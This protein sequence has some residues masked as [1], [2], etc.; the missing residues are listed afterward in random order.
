MEKGDKKDIRALFSF[1]PT[2]KMDRV[3]FLFQL[4]GA[5]FFPQYFKVEDADFHK[6]IDENNYGLYVGK[7]K[8]FLLIGFRGCSKTTREKLWRAFVI[9]ND[10]S[11]SKKY[12]KILTKDIGNAK[13]VVTDIYN[14]LMSNKVLYYYPEIF[15]KTKE[16]REE[17][18]ESFTTTTGIKMRAGTV[19]MDQRGQIQED[20]RPDDIWF[21]DFETRKVLRSA[22][23]IKS[24]SDNMEEA[25]TGLALNG[26]ATYTCNFLSERGNVYYLIEKSLNNSDW[27]VMN[28]PIIKDDKPTW[29]SAYTVE[30]I[31]N[32]KNNAEDFNGEYL[33]D[34]SSGVDVYFDRECLKKQEVV[35]PIKTVAGFKIFYD[36]NPSHKYACGADVG[37]GVGLDHSTSVFIDFTTIP[38]RV[39]ATYKNNTIKPDVFGSELINQGNL[40]GR[41]LI[42]PE[43]NK[44]DMAI[45]VLKMTGYEKIYFTEDKQFKVRDSKPKTY[46]WNTNSMTKNKM[47]SELKSALEAGHLD[48]SDEDIVKELMSYTRDDVM[49]REED[50]RLT[51]RHFDLLIACAI[52]WQMRYIATE[53]REDE[54]E[55]A[56]R[57]MSRFKIMGQ[58][59]K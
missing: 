19:G 1:D 33:G 23:E 11:H 30:D 47:M 8:Y 18:M 21:D 34:P 44:F 36:Y 35:K 57:L 3:V 20:A 12:F 9:A 46:G 51:T 15:K 17:R 55:M 59:N 6:E 26:S 49:D 27:V 50:P 29:A 7:N 52:A 32:I 48:L 31:E 16:K 37:G 28:I 22:V 10:T 39:V 43:N 41:C 4:W 56:D 58:S 13:Q 5:W 25:R 42:A 38:N 45:G 53:A 24:I 54:Q 40:F 14:M 2:T